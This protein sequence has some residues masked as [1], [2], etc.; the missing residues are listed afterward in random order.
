MCQKIVYFNH[1]LYLQ[2]C[3]SAH[4]LHCIQ[5]AKE[6]IG[7]LGQLAHVSCVIPLKESIIS[8]GNPLISRTFQY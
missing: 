3:L 6:E 1:K 5:S 2:Y 8:P 4:I 7:L